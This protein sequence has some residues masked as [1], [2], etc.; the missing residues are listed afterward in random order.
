[1]TRDEIIQLA[2]QRAEAILDQIDQWYEKTG[3]T[4]DLIPLS[5]YVDEETFNFLLP[6]PGWTFQ[7]WKQVNEL[8]ANML[9][10]EGLNVVLVDIALPAYYDFLARYNLSNTP[11]NRALFTGWIIAPEPKPTPLKDSQ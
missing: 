5:N 3:Q 1:M 7:E 9:R 6:S 4:P 8:V 11:A 2:D 10:D